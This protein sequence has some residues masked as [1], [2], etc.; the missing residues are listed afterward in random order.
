MNKQTFLKVILT[1]F[2]S[3]MH[4]IEENNYDYFIFD[5]KLE[6]MFDNVRH[7]H[8]ANYFFNNYGEFYA[9]YMLLKNDSSRALFFKLIIYRLLGHNHININGLRSSDMEEAAKRV[10][11]YCTGTSKFTAAQMLGRT[12]QAYKNYPFKNHT[13]NLE[14]LDI[15]LIFGVEFGQY[16]YEKEGITIKPEKGDIV[17][18]AGSCMGDTAVLF[19]AEVGENGFVHSFDLSPLHLAMTQYNIDNNNFTDRF[20]MVGFGLSNQSNGMEVKPD[21]QDNVVD[22][23]LSL[24]LQNNLPTIQLDEYVAQQ[25]LDKVDFIKMD[26]EGAELMA[27]EG[28]VN[29]IKNHKPKLAISL[30]HKFDDYLAIPH[31]LATEFPFYDL[32]LDHYTL[33]D[34]ET[35]LYAIA[36]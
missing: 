19:S 21:T 14:C 23:S 29:T 33:S 28:A 1:E 9:T 25:S 4:S 15:N 20:K 35:I 8:F 34:Q 31:F 13:L 3:A 10:N 26:I 27:L 5:K 22:P 2:Y 36:R 6:R 18:D 17:I 16:F 24:H 7:G 12:V 32:Y 30:Y 11:A